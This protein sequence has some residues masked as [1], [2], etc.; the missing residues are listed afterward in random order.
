MEAFTHMS[1]FKFDY[2]FSLNS[3]SVESTIR[4]HYLTVV[5]QIQLSYAQDYFE[6][7]ETIFDLLIMQVTKQMDCINQF[8]DFTEPSILM[9]D[10]HL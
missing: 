8:G 2:M 3:S 5:I 4:N 7:S 9:I 1:S 6:S 10:F